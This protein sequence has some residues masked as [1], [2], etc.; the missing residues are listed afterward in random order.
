MTWLTPKS[1]RSFTCPTSALLKALNLLLWLTVTTWLLPTFTLHVLLQK[2]Q[3]A[4]QSNF[5]LY[6]GVT[7]N[8][9]D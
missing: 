7:G 2:L 9:A 3:K 1:A 8:I 6:A 5:T 4:L